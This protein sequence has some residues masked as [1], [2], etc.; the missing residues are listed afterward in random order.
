M[1]LIIIYH[2]YADAFLVIITQILIHII[3]KLLINDFTF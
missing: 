3:I 1:G 2:S